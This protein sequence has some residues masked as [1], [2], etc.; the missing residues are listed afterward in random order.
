MA[1]ISIITW[2]IPIINGIIVGTLSSREE[3]IFR[4]VLLAILN[5]VIAS[6]FY[7]FIDIYFKLKILSPI[8]LAIISAIGIASAIYFAIYT[9][10]NFE[11]VNMTP[12]GITAKCYVKRLKEVK[13][14]V[15]S[16]GFKCFRSKFHIKDEN[17]VEIHFDCDSG[18]VVAKVTKEWK[19]LKVVIRSE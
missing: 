16:L 8:I 18:R 10:L 14:H 6:V 5:S 7:Y 17:H 3:S 15:R 2:P 4:S 1:L 11:E 12:N 19:Y 13:Y 9:K